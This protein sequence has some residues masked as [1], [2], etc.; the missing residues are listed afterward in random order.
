MT[1]LHQYIAEEIATDHAEGLVSRRE[2]MRR[3]ALLGV[4]APAATAL[5]AAC[6]SS[7]TSGGGTSTPAATSAA[8]P[9]GMATAVPTAP[10][11]FP[12]PNGTLQAAWAA[13]AQ[14]KGAVL[15]IHENKGLTD[16]IRSVAGRFAGIGYS[17][18]AVD[19]L[20]AQGGTGAFKDQAEA[21]A[22]LGKIPPTQFVSDLRASLDELSRRA[23]I[24]KLGATGFCFGG[25]LVWLLL[26]QPEPRLTAAT[27]FYGPLPDHADFT[28]DQAAV[29]AVYA[30]EDARVGASRPAAEAAMTKAGL[31]HEVF[32]A[33]G[34]GH[35]FFN[36][37]GP[38]YN[39]PAATQAWQKVTD[40]YGKH[41]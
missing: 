3:L 39:A 13:A 10:I 2:A 7:N 34:A 26:A 30:S 36:D 5:L 4:A 33:Q 18:L 37:T 41:L 35:A 23:P 21:T 8:S 14:P 1:S 9:P 27:P 31:T 17:A 19:L 29:L 20:S 24:Q 12:G 15:V 6:S 22:A 25:G 40:W 38:S 32:V 11:T 28:G 16:H